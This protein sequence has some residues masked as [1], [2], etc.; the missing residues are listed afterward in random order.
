MKEK[1]TQA[2]HIVYGEFI[3]KAMYEKLRKYKLGF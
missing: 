1:L 2:N 3:S